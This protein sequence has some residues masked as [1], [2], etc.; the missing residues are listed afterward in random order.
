MSSSH[1]THFKSRMGFILAA[2]GYALGGRNIWG[3]PTQAASHGGGA[4]LLMY[5]IPVRLQNTCFWS[6]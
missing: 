4:F 3:F 6:A 1:Q 5:I 2:A